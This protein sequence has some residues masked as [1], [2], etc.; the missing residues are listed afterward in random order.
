MLLVLA[1][2]MALALGV[3]SGAFVRRASAQRFSTTASY[4]AE[5]G[6][7]AAWYRIR[8]SEYDGTFNVWLESN[9]LPP[10]DGFPA[11][12]NMPVNGAIVTVTVYKLGNQLYRAESTAVADDQ[13]V[14]VAQEFRGN[15]SL[16]SYMFFN[17][18]DI[19]FG[20]T[21]V[22]GKVHTNGKTQMHYGG[23]VFYDDVTFAKGKKPDYLKGADEANTTFFGKHE[24][25]DPVSIP[26]GDI[27]RLRDFAEPSYMIDDASAKTYIT[28]MRDMV[29]IKVVKGGRVVSD[30]PLPVPSKGV[31]FARGDVYVS[32]DTSVRYTIA[33]LG[34]VFITDRLRYVDQDGDPAYVLKRDGAV[35]PDIDTGPGVAWTAENG[36]EYAPNPDFNPDGGQSPEL[37]IM[38]KKSIE[39]GRDAPYNLELHAALLSAEGKVSFSLERAK[40]NLRVVGSLASYEA[41]ARYQPDSSLEGYKGWGL[42]GEYIYDENL[43]ATP[44]PHYLLANRP[45]EGPRWRM[46]VEEVTHVVP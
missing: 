35:V 7:E 13:R 15:H 30:L 10:P 11:I 34:R 43:G 21:V 45:E 31:I 4:A 44:P 17:Q 40:G 42:S 6:L 2:G 3:F 9:S 23:A 14:T 46:H 25:V 38:A 26:V 5:A 27:A 16:A 19:K 22:R 39:I 33:S 18:K 29:R 41:G 8:A 28:A 37:G 24:Q 36:F 1:A 32:G 12:T 20:K